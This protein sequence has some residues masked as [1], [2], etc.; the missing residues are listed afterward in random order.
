MARKQRDYKAEYARRQALAR[1]RGFKSYAQQ[2]REIEKG[3]YPALA[4]TRL[5]KA[6]TIRNQ[7]EK[8]TGFLG[9][10]LAN[11]K[12][13][14]IEAAQRWS[15]MRART[16]SMEFD[17]KRARRDPEYL[18]AYTAATVL[19]MAHPDTKMQ[20]KLSANEHSKHL[21][22]DVLGLMTADE[23]E[24]RYGQRK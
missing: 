14:R 7:E 9:R 1:E 19:D 8:G 13:H 12:D 22:V 3:D 23:Y 10:T 16:K 15:D 5:R 20:A 21:L 6:S 17:A 2:R 24:T 11:L 18:N 4:P